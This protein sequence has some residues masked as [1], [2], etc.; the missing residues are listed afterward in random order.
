[1]EVS[2]S[3]GTVE[4][5]NLVFDITPSNTPDN[6]SFGY[7]SNSF[8]IRDYEMEVTIHSVGEEVK[9]GMICKNG[10]LRIRLSETEIP[11]DPAPEE[12]VDPDTPVDPEEPEIPEEPEVPAVNV[13]ITEENGYIP[14]ASKWNEEKYVPNGLLITKIINGEMLNDE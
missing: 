7:V 13:D 8:M 4:P 11:D 3:E 10:N 14:N 5:T 1:M 6:G 12:P 2:Y 9:V